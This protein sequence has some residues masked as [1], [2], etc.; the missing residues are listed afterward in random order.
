M[1][2]WLDRCVAKVK[3]KVKNPYAVCKAAHKKKRRKK[4]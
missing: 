4:K 3:G 2:K 1:P